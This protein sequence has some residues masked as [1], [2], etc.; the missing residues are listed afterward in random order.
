MF[1]SNLVSDLNAQ[2]HLPHTNFDAD[3]VVG[4]NEGKESFIIPRFSKRQPKI[5]KCNVNFKNL[6]TFFWVS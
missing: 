3:L 1:I 6:E 4:H 2:P 5:V